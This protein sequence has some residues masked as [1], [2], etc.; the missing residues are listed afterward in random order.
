MATQKAPR[1]RLESP[2]PKTP[3]IAGGQNVAV[4]FQQ[5]ESRLRPLTGAS[6]ARRR[7]KPGGPMRQVANTG[8]DGCRPP[9]S[10]AVA[11][12]MCH[13][14]ITVTFYS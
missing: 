3:A 7:H 14:T 4:G 13:R 8:P 12:D 5:T 6:V 9:P 10:F 1:S 2:K 11:K